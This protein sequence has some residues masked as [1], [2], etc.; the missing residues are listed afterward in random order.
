MDLSF[1]PQEQDFRAEVRDFFKTAMPDDMR[2]RVRLGQKPT[3]DDLV[4]WQ[5]ILDKKG[6]A[7]PLAAKKE[8]TSGITRFNKAK[9][10]PMF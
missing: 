4:T 6:W 3:R 10:K 7:G 2:K 8:I 5:R 9:K 1:T